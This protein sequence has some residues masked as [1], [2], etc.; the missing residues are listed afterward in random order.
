MTTAAIAVPMSVASILERERDSTIKEWLKR[1]NLVPDLISIVL[2]DVNRTGHLPRLLDDVVLRLRGSDDSA[3]PVASNAAAEHG[4]A[5]LAQGYT[6]PMLVEESRLFQVS[7]FN[8]LRLFQSELDQNIVLA[9]AMI[10]ADEA[11]RQLGETV[12]S[13]MKGA[14]TA[15]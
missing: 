2:S 6:L 11:D 7:T 10:I 13:F 4:A 15:Q 8:T 14:A 9:D 5:R 12:R 3:P 1:V